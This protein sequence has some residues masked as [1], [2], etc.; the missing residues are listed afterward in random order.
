MPPLYRGLAVV[1]DAPGM[2]RYLVLTVL[3]LAL[4]ATALGGSAQGGSW[5]RLP[6]APITP[7]WNARTSVW[8]G[9]QMIV[10]GRDQ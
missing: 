10:F 7:D 1:T 3:A 2:N 5:K 4:P 9:K 8:T 6:A